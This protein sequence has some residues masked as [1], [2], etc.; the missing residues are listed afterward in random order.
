MQ[1]AIALLHNHQS[2]FFDEWHFPE[3]DLLRAYSLFLMCKFPEASAR[4]DR[5]VNTHEP[6]QKTMDAALATITPREAFEDAR[7]AKEGKDTRIPLGVL[8]GFTWEDRFADAVKSV[9]AADDETKRLLGQASQAFGARANEWLAL[10]RDARKD[11]AGERVIERVKR[12]RAE[13]TEMLTGVEITRLDL[14]NFET[15]LYEQA[16]QTGA[17]DIGD[18]IGKLRKIRKRRGSWVWPFEGEYWADELGWYRVDA[19]QIVPQR[20]REH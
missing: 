4:I 6:R 5:F 8:R 3:A 15:Q 16:A 10:R 9:D 17:L 13:I 12:A 7:R 20:W 2:P 14:L 19:R 1:G 18:R 11:A